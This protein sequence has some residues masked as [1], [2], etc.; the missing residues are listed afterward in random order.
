[1]IIGEIIVIG[2]SLSEYNGDILGIN[3]GLIDGDA[4][5]VIFPQLKLVK[6]GGI[7]DCDWLGDKDVMDW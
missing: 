5:I 7:T 3:E 1:M 6:N 2:V 4:N